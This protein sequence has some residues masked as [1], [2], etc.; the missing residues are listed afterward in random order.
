MDQETTAAE[1]QSVVKHLHFDIAEF[2]NR[3]EAATAKLKAQ[4]L[5]AL[6]MFRQESMYYLTGYDTFG[7]VFFQCL[8]MTADG[9]CVLLT[10]AP[11]LRQAKFTSTMDD[12]RV[13]KDGVSAN[14][15]ADLAR[16]A[17]RARLAR[18]PARHRDRCA[19]PYGAQLHSHQDRTH[20]LRRTGGSLATR[21][22]IALGQKPCGNR[23]C[24]AR[25]RTWRCSSRG[26]NCSNRTGCQRERYS[27]RYAQCHLSWWWRRSGQRIHHR[28]RA[29]AP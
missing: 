8:V 12:I 3:R 29:P 6:L 7:Y 22:R 24:Q 17:R 10:R 25:R 2:E 23:L 26:S 16:A 18:L 27:S 28:F 14:P 11:D 20:R 4:G 9:N 19:R 13:W 15:A 21:L 1:P 5:D